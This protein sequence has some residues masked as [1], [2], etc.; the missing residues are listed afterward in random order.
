MRLTKEDL[1]T[2]LDNE[3]ATVLSTRQGGMAICIV[4]LNAGTDMTP[5]LQG[6]K[7]DM[8][9]CPHF[10]YILRGA[11]HCRYSDGTEETLRP[12]EIWYA[13]PGHTVW[14]E[15]DTELVEFSP[16]D[17]YQEVIDHISSK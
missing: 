9:Q 11:L 7:D 12:G 4:K 3:Q 1:E 5:A 17:A 2:A 16:E 13:P 6:L 10:G 15:E 14:V 8:C